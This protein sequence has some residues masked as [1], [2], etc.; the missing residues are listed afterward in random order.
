ML[1]FRT[2]KKYYT[3]SCMQ[4]KF[5]GFTIEHLTVLKV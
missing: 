4:P 3:E 1:T 2:L 5:F